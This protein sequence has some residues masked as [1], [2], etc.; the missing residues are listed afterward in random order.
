VLR[1]LIGDERSLD[2][3]FQ[4]IE[5]PPRLLGWLIAFL[6][7]GMGFQGPRKDRGDGRKGISLLLIS[8]CMVT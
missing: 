1:R 5:D 2:V 4:D 3:V 7:L 8:R 6:F